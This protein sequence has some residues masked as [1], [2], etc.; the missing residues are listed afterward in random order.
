MRLR[1]SK[2]RLCKD[3]I[4]LRQD[5]KS[6]AICLHPPKIYPLLPL[7]CQGQIEKG[8]KQRIIHRN[9]IAQGKCCEENSGKI[10][11]RKDCSSILDTDIKMV[12]TRQKCENKRK[13][14]ADIKNWN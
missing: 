5:G 14:K 11:R 4:C 6:F 2:M 10:G 13:E 8:R 3:N 1:L 9:E 12:K 7:C